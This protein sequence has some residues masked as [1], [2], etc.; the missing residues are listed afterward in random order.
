MARLDDLNGGRCPV[1]G[2]WWWDCLPCLGA[3]HYEW[4]PDERDEIGEAGA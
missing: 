2:E 1:T 3:G 4:A